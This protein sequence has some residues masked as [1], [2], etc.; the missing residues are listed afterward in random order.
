MKEQPVI[1]TTTQSLENQNRKLLEENKELYKKIKD[2]LALA[3]K[4]K[5]ECVIKCVT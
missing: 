1:H 3:E 5:V 2:A 4:E